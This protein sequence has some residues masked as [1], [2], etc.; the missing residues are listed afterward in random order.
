MILGLL[1][2]TVVEE[3]NGSLR[4]MPGKYELKHIKAAI[5]QNLGVQMSISE[6]EFALQQHGFEVKRRK[7]VPRVEVTKDKLKKA[8]A[9]LNIEDEALSALC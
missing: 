6:I 3:S 4:F 8:C 2:V 5:D 1:S 7:G 9:E